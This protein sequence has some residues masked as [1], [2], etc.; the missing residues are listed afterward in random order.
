MG[1]ILTCMVTGQLTADWIA[2]QDF[3]YCRLVHSGHRNV[4]TTCMNPIIKNSSGAAV[5]IQIPKF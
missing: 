2:V 4:T 3:A 5:G 1:F